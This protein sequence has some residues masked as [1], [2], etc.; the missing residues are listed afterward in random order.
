MGQRFSA[1]AEATLLA[2]SM[3]GNIDEVKRLVGEFIGESKNSGADA[4]KGFV[5]RKDAPGNC[6]LH[7][8]VFS[9]HLEVG[10]CSSIIFALSSTIQY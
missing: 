7:C 10:K 1:T 2:P 3:E 6:A 8:A 5:D 4:L 9:G